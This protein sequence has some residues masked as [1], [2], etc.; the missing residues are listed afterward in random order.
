M[1]CF[2]HFTFCCFAQLLFCL[3]ANLPFVILLN[4]CIALPFYLLLFYS[5]AVCR[6]AILPFVILLN[7]CFA[8]LPIYCQFTF[9][10]LHY[11]HFAFAPSKTKVFG[12]T[13]EAKWL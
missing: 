11:C 6:I 12:K 10:Y 1:V 9:C 7:F 8:L 5:I 4:C 2:W 13:K 3:I